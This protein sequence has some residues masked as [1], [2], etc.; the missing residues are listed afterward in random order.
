MLEEGLE[1]S[2]A[3]AANWM[4]WLSMAMLVQLWLSCM[5]QP[6]YARGMYQNSLGAFANNMTEQLPSIG[7]QIT[8]WMFNTTVPAFCI[9]ALVAQDVPGGF[10]LFGRI[11]LMM[12]GIDL[13]RI[14]VAWLVYYAFRLGKRFIPMYLRYYALRSLTMFLL[15]AEALVLGASAHPMA[16]VMAMA[17]TYLVFMLLL[18]VQLARVICTSWVDVLSIMIYILTVELLPMLVLYYAAMQLYPEYLTI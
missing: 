18:G 4:P 9:Y 2:R 12:V 8:Q 7:S 5:L 11:L 16:W 1:I 3:L 6:Q 15:F 10:G 13:L 17:L 14:V